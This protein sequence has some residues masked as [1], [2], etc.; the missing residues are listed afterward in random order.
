M[1]AADMRAHA[2]PSGAPAIRHGT[3]MDVQ[4]GQRVLA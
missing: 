1:L 2:A 4:P 3:H